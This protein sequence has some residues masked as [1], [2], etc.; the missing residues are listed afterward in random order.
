MNPIYK[1]KVWKLSKKE[2]KSNKKKVP[3]FIRT[4]QCPTCFLNGRH[5]N[6]LMRCNSQDAGLA[7]AIWTVYFGIFN[8]CGSKLEAGEYERPKRKIRGR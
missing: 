2:K 4:F 8:V 7:P 6:P 1:L 3:F 5:N